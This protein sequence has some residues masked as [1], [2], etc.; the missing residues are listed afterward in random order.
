M[1]GPAIRV[2]IRY[3]DIGTVIGAGRRPDPPLSRFPRRA[4]ALGERRGSH[5]TPRGRHIDARQDRRRGG[6]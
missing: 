6:R 3:A 5:C 1:S 4:T 2:D